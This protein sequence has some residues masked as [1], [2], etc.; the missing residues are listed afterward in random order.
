[1]RRNLALAAFASDIPQSVTAHSG[2]RSRSVRELAR[3]WRVSTRKVR[4][5]IRRGLLRAID[6]GCGRQQL[7]LTPEAVRACEQRLAVRQPAARRR[8]RSEVDPEI[9]RLLSD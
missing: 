3:Y 7:R 8:R 9:E 6:L 1:M 4:A 2:D 5:L